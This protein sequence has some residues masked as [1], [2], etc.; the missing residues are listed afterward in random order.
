MGHCWD[1]TKAAPASQ[2]GEAG[3]DCSG[4]ILQTGKRTIR[5]LLI[6]SKWKKK[7]TNYQQKTER[8]LTSLQFTQLGGDLVVFP[9]VW[10]RDQRLWTESWASPW[11]SL[12]LFI[13]IIQLIHFSFCC[14]H[15]RNR[16]FVVLLIHIIKAAVMKRQGVRRL[17]K[18]QGLG[19]GPLHWAGESSHCNHTDMIH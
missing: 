14:D 15:F 12:L 19:V 13:V 11:V 9:V 7:K 3:T 5:R 16:L 1:K 6:F 10:L 2:Q 4:R 18:K 17:G 8:N